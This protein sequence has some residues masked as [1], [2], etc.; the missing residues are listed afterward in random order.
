MLVKLERLNVVLER[1]RRICVKHNH[2]YTGE[3]K[4]AEFLKTTF[5]YL[6]DKDLTLLLNFLHDENVDHF[7]DIQ[8]RMF[9]N[10]QEKK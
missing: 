6:T 9:I 8:M 10:E 3:D 1:T 2:P 5:E 7:F 4:E